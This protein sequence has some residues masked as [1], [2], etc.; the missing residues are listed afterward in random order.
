MF[1]IVQNNQIQQLIPDGSQFTLDGVEYPS[2]WVNLS[3]PEEKT[4][5]GMVD[6][7]YGP[8]P[9]DTYYWV[10]QEPAVYNEQTNQVDINFTFTPKDLFTLQNDQVTATNNTAY[11]ILQ[12][13]DWMV[14]RAIETSTTVDPAWNAWRQEIRDQAAAQVA[15]ITACTDV[16][17]LAALPPV[18]WANDPN[19][20]ATA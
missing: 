14:V 20:V 16:A 3:T 11:T 2:N 13:S 18:A 10:T 4:T 15:K 1:A 12:P 17:E 8:A 5:I 19:Y 9:S 6:V 7:V